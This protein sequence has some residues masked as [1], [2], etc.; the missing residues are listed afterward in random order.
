MVLTRRSFALATAGLLVAPCR[1]WAA[2]PVLIG[3]I[4]SITGPAAEPGKLAT[5]GLNL[6]L[7]EVNKEGVLGRQVQVVTE[8]DQTTNPGTVLAFS[9][10]ARQPEIVAFIAPNRSTQVNAMAPDVLKI[11]KPMIVRR[12]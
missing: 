2:D 9:R 6:A 10:L 1:T 11:G 8:D 7:E 12:H 3:M 5:N 4:L